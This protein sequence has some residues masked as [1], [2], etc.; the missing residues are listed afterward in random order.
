METTQP[1]VVA[2]LGSPRE[3]NTS[4]LVDVALE[5]FAARGAR[6]EKI[7]LVEWR[8]LPCEGHDECASLPGRGRHAAALGE[9]LWR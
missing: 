8:I 7:R 5:E 6:T 9:G 2:V 1:T 4:Y 3:G